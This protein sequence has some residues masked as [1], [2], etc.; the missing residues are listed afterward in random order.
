MPDLAPIK[1]ALLSVSDKTGLVELARFLASQ[2]VQLVST[3]GTARALRDA[4]LAVVPID[5]L[6][7]FPEIMDGRVKT[8]HP[9]V[10]GGLLFVRDNPAHVE[11]ARAQEISPIDLVCVN[12]YPFE[13]TI[14]KSGVTH[15]EAIEQIDIGGPSMLRSAAKNFEHVTVLTSPAQYERVI[16]EMKASQGRTTRSLRAQLAQEV[17]AITSRY[18]AAIAAYLA[19][20]GDSIFPPLLSL[21]F[22][23]SEE[24]RYGENPHQR[25]AVYRTLRREA[26]PGAHEPSVAS[27]EQLHG[28]ELSYN[29]LLDAAAA[30]SLA[31]ALRRVDPTRP[32]AVVVKHTNPCGAAIAASGFDAIDHA[33][34]GDPIAAYGGI[35]AVNFQLDAAA[36]RRLESKDLFLEVIIAPSFE[37]EALSMLRAR[38][39]NVRLLAVGSPPAD[40]SASPS[41]IAPQAQVEYR[42]IPGGLLAQERD[43][44]LAARSELTHAAGPAPTPVTLELAMFLEAVVRSLTSNAVCIGNAAKGRDGG[45]LRLLGAGAGQMD[46]LTSSRLA[47]EKAQASLASPL[48]GHGTL[49]ASDAFFPFPDGPELL[50]SAGVTAIVHPG[51]SKRDGETFDLCNARNATCLTSGLRHFRH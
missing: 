49:A 10:H 50:I 39:A 7:G 15:E 41:H 32:G 40:V 14:E 27:A 51:G 47:V 33:I 9:K 45:V 30:L 43:L 13:A 18:D 3:G 48:K 46:R 20:G 2:G 24:L 26:A 1:R 25:A 5:D 8:L 31:V 44:R 36:A 38:W 22:V 34:A 42:S 28:K 11:Q 29:N 4:G 6:T 23:R 12:L 35:L 17:F 21:S 37:P 16:E 19:R